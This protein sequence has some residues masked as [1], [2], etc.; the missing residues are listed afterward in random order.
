MWERGEKKIRHSM[1][2]KFRRVCVA[3]RM[4]GVIRASAQVKMMHN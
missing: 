2:E 1:D 4:I 3:S